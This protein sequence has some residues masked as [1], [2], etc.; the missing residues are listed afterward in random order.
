MLFFTICFIIILALN[1]IKAPKVRMVSS[2]YVPN[3][4]LPKH[5]NFH[6]FMS[7]V[8]GTGQ[9]RTHAITRK[10]QLFFPGLKVWLDVDELQDISKLEESVAES[11]V[12]V[13]F[14]SK[15][16][17]QSK[18][19]RREIYAAIKLDKPVI[20]LYKGDESV[21]EEMQEECM[22]NCLGVEDG[23]DSPTATLIL[24]KLLGVDNDAQNIISSMDSSIMDGPIEWLNEGSFSAAA[25]NRIYTRVLYNLPYYKRYPN[26]LLDQ[27][28]TVP[29]ELGPVHLHS[30]INIL[31]HASNEGCSDVVAELK[32][33]MLVPNQTDSEDLID[34]LN[35]TSYLQDMDTQN[36][37]VADSNEDVVNDSNTSDV[38]EEVQYNLPSSSANTSTKP[39]F[40]LL[41][42]N[43][44]TF[45][46]DDQDKKELTSIIQSCIDDPNIT[47]VLIHEKD[48]FRGGCEF[49]DFFVK[50]P[51]ELIKPPNYLFR[52]IA[53]PLYASRA[54]RLVSLR[55]IACKMGA[56]SV[57]ANNI[58]MLKMSFMNSL[59]KCLHIVKSRE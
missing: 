44:Y 7:H 3:L 11:A 35:V 33:M 9:A 27:G 57:A 54:Y 59:K 42:L 39:T 50:T 36:D 52:D 31:V 38:R 23:T 56:V 24:Q 17:F 25:L 8:W 4:E 43:R 49:A 6:V 16:Y 2:G 41:Y 1:K 53:I 34:I 22:N 37:H 13:L 46:G 19:C 10:M 45:E 20:L 40:F 30:P 26:E 28:I 15:H 12:F 51:E 55:Q 32:A 47:I 14:Y 48:V 21:L 58:E 18:N 5:C 29:G